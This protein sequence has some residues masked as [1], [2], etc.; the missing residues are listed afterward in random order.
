MSVS[1]SSLMI[2]TTLQIKELLFI[3][4]KGRSEETCK[5]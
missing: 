1:D 3:L 2:P 5:I 4:K